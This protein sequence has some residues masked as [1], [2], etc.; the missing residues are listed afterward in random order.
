MMNNE[1]EIPG[2]VPV[3]TLSDTVLFPQAMMPLYIFEPRYRQMLSDVL[4]HE[5]IFAVA[6]V[7]TNQEEAEVLETPYKIAGVGMVRACKQNPDGT[8]NLILQGL[9]RVQFEEIVSEEPYRRA[10]ISQIMS[11]SDG[12]EKTL[13]AIQ[14]TVLG[15]VQTQIRLG[16]HIPKEILQFLSNIRE[17]E[18]VLDLAIF[19]LCPAGKFK[20]ELLET[21]GIL[22]RY[23][24]FER[25]L[26]E[27]VERLKMDRKLKGGLEENDLGNN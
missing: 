9:A 7:D 20:Q 3:M 21:R 12:S 26:Q 22:A 19:T 24:K 13:S 4:N 23:E 14:P 17:P 2:E 10:R 5:R 27:Q 1:I 8:S 15:L 11:E 18:S 25:L 16:A 6:A